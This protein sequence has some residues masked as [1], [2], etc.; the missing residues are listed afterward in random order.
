MD[1]TGNSA[2]TT[3]A[4]MF[5]T[6]PSSSDKRV[7]TGVETAPADG[8]ETRRPDRQKPAKGRRPKSKAEQSRA[9][10]R[11]N[12]NKAALARQHPGARE[13]RPLTCGKVAYPDRGAAEAALVVIQLRGEARDKTPCRAYDCTTCEFWHL[14]SQPAA[15]RN[16]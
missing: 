3:G 6:Q 15:P 10:T 9:A 7:N 4:E 12:R 13:I 5:T 11:R 16:C 14:T 8:T 1:H 2:E